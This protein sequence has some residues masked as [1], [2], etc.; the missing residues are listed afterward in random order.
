[1]DTLKSEKALVS[2][3]QWSCDCGKPASGGNETT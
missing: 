2:K 3:E 1:M